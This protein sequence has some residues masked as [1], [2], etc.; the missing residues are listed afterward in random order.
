MHCVSYRRLTLWQDVSTRIM[1]F[2]PCGYFVALMSAALLVM[3]P[4]G[5]ETASEQAYFQE[6][7]V[8]LT[9]SRLSQPL[10][11]APSAITVI[12]REMIKASGF[13]TIPELM[14]LV[15]GMYVGFADANRPIVSFHGS[16]DEYSHRMQILIDGRS[17]YM[18]PFGGVNWADIP[19]VLDDIERIEV[20]RGPSSASFGTNSFYGV[21]N[22]ITQDAAT[23]NGGSISVTGG[24][25]SDA[26]AR[27]GKSGETLDYRLTAGYRSDPGLDNG[28][29]NDHNVTRVATLRST[30]HPTNSDSI[31]VQIGNSD[32]TYGMGIRGRP[33]DAFRDTFK[34][35]A[36]QEVSLLH[37][38]DSGG[39]SKVTY[40]HN[41][42]N[43][44]DPY[45]CVDSGT[46]QGYYLPTTPISKGFVQMAV[47]SQR[48]ELEV[49]NT[50]W[51]GEHNRLVWGAN[52]RRDYADYPL[53]L[54]QPYTVS[55]WQLFAHDE[56]RLTSA[57]ILNVGSMLEDNGM[58]DRSVSPRASVNYHLTPEHTIRFGI[59]TATR[60]PVMSESYIA[61]NNTIWG[62]AYV[63][64]V[65]PLMPERIVSREVG[66]VGEFRSLALTVDARAYIDQVSGLIWW[67]KYV[68]L[69]SAFPDS[70][71]NLFAAEYRGVD[72]T[73]KY[74]WN[75]GRSFGVLNYA[76]QQAT[77]SLDSIPTQYYNTT[78]DPLDPAKYSSVGDR[79][80]QFYQTEYL[81]QFPQTVPQHS[82]SLLVSQAVG[83]DWQLSGGYYY[84]GT[85]RVGDVSPDVTPE[86]TMRRFDIRIAR[87]YQ[88]EHG[89]SLEFAGVVQNV[90]EDAY[91]KYG[92]VNATA[93]V[94]FTRRGWVTATLNY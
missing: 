88:L 94:L 73:L 26:V 8:V 18:P 70:F 43:L 61:A 37:V 7:P 92:T 28:I 17:I 66:Y 75:E 87:K 29:L 51:L 39:E 89:R 31:D 86:Y 64:P 9:A 41:S 56:W 81:S 19:L 14:R 67:D 4:A 91:T 90:T 54:G 83:H 48:N 45:L 74:H 84:R 47:Y 10:S 65:T 62:G 57:A 25:A 68:Q 80:R 33:E 30:Y 46:C 93:Q 85:M 77:A 52:I 16:S 1:N 6:L 71:K 55:S 11:E 60:S 38:W 49:Q 27:I 36:Y 34:S 23:L 63:P 24:Y 15:P 76:Y 5:A 69:S 53:F 20:V 42:H 58:G 59:S 82:V 72:A 44:L 2:F 21:I 22:I 50:N 79:V 40:S 12:D 35:S 13:R 32:G 78:A 3:Q